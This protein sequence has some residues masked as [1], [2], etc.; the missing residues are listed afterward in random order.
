MYIAIYGH[1]STGCA[2]PRHRA[3]HW[4]P[5]VAFMVLPKTAYLNSLWDAVG[6]IVAPLGIIFTRVCGLG[7]PPVAGVYF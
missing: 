3:C 7:R 4:F 6:V 2:Q 5:F 1:A